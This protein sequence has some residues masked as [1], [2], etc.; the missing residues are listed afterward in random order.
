MSWEWIALYSPFARLRWLCPPEELVQPEPNL[1]AVAADGGHPA[2]R[3]HRGYDL[4]PERQ[5]FSAVVMKCCVPTRPWL[6][7][8]EGGP[9]WRASPW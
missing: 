7:L 1:L 4:D 2:Q 9:G 6:H 5:Y 3:G 8:F